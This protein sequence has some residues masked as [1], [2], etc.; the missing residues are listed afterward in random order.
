MIN[1]EEMASNEANVEETKKQ[2]EPAKDEKPAEKVN[3]LED[4]DWDAYA[5]EGGYSN[6]R[7]TE[8]EA[9]YDETLSSVGEGEVVD[10]TVISMNK[11]EVVINIGYKSEGVVSLNEFRYNPELQVGDTV[12]VYVGEVMQREYA[13]HADDNCGQYDLRNGPILKKQLTDEHVVLPNA[14]F[15]Q[16]ET[17]HQT[18][19][20]ARNQLGSRVHM[21][22]GHFRRLL[23]G[24][25][26]IDHTHLTV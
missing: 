20:R 1:Q 15:L 18:K 11:R 24:F 19:D 2:V 26:G 8:L 10:G 13:D 6:D 5:E 21:W 22:R 4:F 25:A 16:Q 3:P 12:E 7:K 23:N 9:M 14:P 17:K